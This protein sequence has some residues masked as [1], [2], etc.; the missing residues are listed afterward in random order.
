MI[1][2]QIRRP[3]SAR[4]LIRPRAAP[5]RSFAQRPVER[6]EW[7]GD[8]DGPRTFGQWIKEK[9]QNIVGGLIIISVTGF[10]YEKVPSW[11]EWLDY[12][13]L[14]VPLKTIVDEEHESI[15][16]A[17][18]V[19]NP[20]HQDFGAQQPIIF[21]DELRVL[22]VEPGSGADEIRCRRVNVAQS[23]RTRY[24]AL[25]YTWGDETQREDIVV[26]GLRTSV[27]Q[28][29]HSALKHLRHPRRTRTLWVDALCINQGDA[30]EREEQVR[31]MGSIY[32]QARRVVIWLGEET[33]EVQGA[34]ALV[35]EVGASWR[36][37]S[38]PQ[39]MPKK[40]YSDFAPVFAL[41]R[42][43]WFQRTWII[44]EAVLAR[45]SVLVCGHETIPWKTFTEC[46][47]SKAFHELVPPDDEE[48]EHGLRAIAMIMHGRHEA[49]TKF[50]RR[51]KKKL[52]YEPDF[53]LMST[54]YETR[55]FQCKDDRD[56]I[57]SLLSMVTNVEPDDETIKPN[58]TASPEDVFEAVARWDIE[59]NQSLE[60]LSY[61]SGVR[62]EHADLPSWVPDFSSLHKVS[63]VAS[64]MKLKPPSGENPGFG[65]QYR[66]VFHKDHDGKTLLELSVAM[67]DTI[68]WV[69][70]VAET[71]KIA[72]YTVH[73]GPEGGWTIDLDLAAISSRTEW[74]REC[75]KI[76][77][78]ADPAPLFAIRDPSFW[79]SNTLGL[80]RNH[81]KSFEALMLPS[82]YRALD[83]TEYARFLGN[84]DNNGTER[85][86]TW[87][88]ESFGYGLESI[89][90]HLR[91]FAGGRRFCAT[92]TGKIGWVPA[93]AAP[94][95]LVCLVS[96]G[97]VPIIIRRTLVEGRWLRYQLIGDSLILGHM[98]KQVMEVKGKKSKTELNLHQPG[99][100]E[101]VLIR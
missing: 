54:L 64:L 100:Y 61:C 7:P 89:D 19:Y 9:V 4:F 31:K 21:P 92:R 96:G 6:P 51:G 1:I 56:R 44:Q 69:G 25:S 40:S 48:V 29:L 58:Y 66:P 70:K 98:D 53:R 45:D 97:A 46:C 36:Y 95:D 20:T 33:K 85:K 93:G 49:H 34:M 76:A 39:D 90:Q 35:K 71:P 55:G 12:A 22:V 11:D 42:R 16:S 86:T 91:D 5:R 30:E 26:D 13:C 94:G 37:S 15:I 75:V 73:N 23:W 88:G 18:T 2:R 84:T 38:K 50:I 24:D 59:K 8:Q 62:G 79:K 60:I 83:L 52:K 10:V 41:L 72:F 17:N 74:L 43:P 65:D 14:A 87:N 78:A 3:A 47:D 80:S 68:R 99:E 27:T 63:S 101:R 82:S 81:F 57:Y 67:V 28:N 77:A 32:S